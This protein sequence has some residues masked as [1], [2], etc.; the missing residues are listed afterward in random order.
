[1][2]TVAAPSGG[3][4]IKGLGI[5]IG[6]GAGNR[7]WVTAWDYNDGLIL[8]D[9]T[10]STLTESDRHTLGF[11]SEAEVNS[12]T[13]IAYPYGIFGSDD[14]V[15]VF[16]RMDDPQGLSS[17]EHIIYTG[18]A[19][20]SFSSI[21][22]NWLGNHCGSIHYLT[23]GDLYAIRNDGSDTRLYIGTL[24][25]SMVLASLLPLPAGVEPHGMIVDPFSLSVVACS[26][27]AGSVMVAKSSSP[28]TSW[29][30]FTLDHQTAEG[31][32]AIAIL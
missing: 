19:G 23:N 31:V 22:N 25:T 2:A 32:N 30:D 1:M 24:I 7:I 15:V 28:Y 3:R 18:N 4:E 29:D 16:G 13:W 17:P 5:S 6:K 12:K 10:L 21:E 20:A 8:I 26:R 11:A 9:V 27:I 14:A